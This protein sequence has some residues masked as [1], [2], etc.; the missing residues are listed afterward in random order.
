MDV[1]V[2]KQT[3]THMCGRVSVYTSR[4]TILRLTIIILKELETGFY[5][6]S[7]RTCDWHYIR[8]QISKVTVHRF[9][10]YFLLFQ[11]QV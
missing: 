7:Q 4:G 5:Y 1:C 3:Y 6:N 9:M 2:H 10:N 8:T 11:N